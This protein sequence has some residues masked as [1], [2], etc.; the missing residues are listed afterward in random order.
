M[1]DRM[2]TASWIAT[3]AVFAAWLGVKPAAV[4]R[5]NNVPAVQCASSDGTFICTS[6][7]TGRRCQ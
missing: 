6:A 2:R 7:G 4:V 1:G 5:E 3:M